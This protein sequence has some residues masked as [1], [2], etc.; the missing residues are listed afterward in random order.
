QGK[1]MSR[2]GLI[3]IAL[4]KNEAAN[5]GSLKKEFARLT[6]LT[7]GQDD[8]TKTLKLFETDAA[9]NI[10]DGN[11][12]FMLDPLGNLMMRYKKDVRLIGIIKDMEHLLKVS[13]IG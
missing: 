9:I 10:K 6:V 1:A 5:A 7:G 2:V 4:D 3:Y 13:Q 12:I 8:I 11:L